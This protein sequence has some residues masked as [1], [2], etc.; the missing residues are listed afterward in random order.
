MLFIVAVPDI[1]INKGATSGKVFKK[2]SAT[3]KITNYV[4]VG[5]SKLLYRACVAGIHS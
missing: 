2:Q 1:V 5:L 4:M 3:G